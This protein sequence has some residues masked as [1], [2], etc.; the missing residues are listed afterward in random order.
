[1][2]DLRNGQD[3][4]ARLAANDLAALWAQVSNAAEA[5]VALHDV[6][7]NL[8]RTYGLAA[9]A[10]A[11]DWYDEAREMASVGGSFQA[12]PAS[13]DE[14]GTESL[15]QWATQHGTDMPALQELI[16]GGMQRRIVNWSRATV[17][18]SSLQDPRADGWQRVGVGECEFCTMLISRGAVYDKDTADFGAHD[19]CNCA[20]APAF[21]GRPRPV[22]PYTPSARA[23]DKRSN[24][25]KLAREWI[26]GHL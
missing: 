4:L 2:A 3:A 17:M 5:R 19:H 8:I 6:L 12:I 10:M 7:P 16:E 22:E 20:A 24:D 1:M 14:Q 11:A 25:R 21:H 18:G 13:L 26:E 15:I 9:S 23:K